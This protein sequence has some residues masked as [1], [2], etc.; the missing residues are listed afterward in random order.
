MSDHLTIVRTCV[1]MGQAG[2]QTTWA[3]RQ[4]DAA[5]SRGDLDLIHGYAAELPN[6]VDLERAVRILDVIRDRR[7]DLYDKAAG[8][9]VAKLVDKRG[10]GLA[11]LGE[12]VDALDPVMFDVETLRRLAST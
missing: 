4:L 1:R 8:R 9:F 12:L 3:L 7:P 10:M 11:E 2:H 6:G 5:I